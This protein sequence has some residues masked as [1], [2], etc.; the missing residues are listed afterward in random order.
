MI[1][2]ELW[3]HNSV[4]VF[5][6]Y[7][8]DFVYD[9]KQIGDKGLRHWEPDHK[10]WVVRTAIF[11]D[12]HALLDDYFPNEEWAVAQ[13]A[14]DAIQMVYAKQVNPG[15]AKAASAQA[16][17]PPTSFGPYA[18]LYINDSAPDCVVAAAHKALARML[19]PDL[20][21][22]R[23]AMAAVNAAFEQIKKARGGL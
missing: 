3:D 23:D 19:H 6:P 4:A 11:A 2:I 21:G 17:G 10:A 16:V 22:D 7:N 8:R 14:Q 13:D 9:L 1:V 5:S 20:G 12:V 18:T 15:G